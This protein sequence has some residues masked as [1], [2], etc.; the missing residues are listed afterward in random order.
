MALVFAHRGAHSAERENT[1]GA[2]RAALE[3]GVDGVEL[4]VRRTLDGAL[5]IH[6]DPEAQGVVIAHARADEL[7]SFVPHLEESLEVLGDVR[8]NVEVKN[9]KDEKEPTYDESGTFVA[10]VIEVLRASGRLAS[11][12]LSCFDLA[13]CVAARAMEPALVVA[14][15]NWTSP[16]L[17]ALEV[18]STNGLS[19]VNPHFLLVDAEGQARAEALGLDLNVWTVNDAADLTSMGALGVRGVITDQPDLAVSLLHGATG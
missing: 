4:D 15:L 11:L 2:F 16:L 17:D 8:V 9:I 7:P 19:A 1:L 18:A 10:A 5:V 6:H 13:T 14:W 12:E 3:I